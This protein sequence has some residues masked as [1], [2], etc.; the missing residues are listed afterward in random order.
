MLPSEIPAKSHVINT[1]E[2]ST[3]ARAAIAMVFTSSGIP[4][5]ASGIDPSDSKK[6]ARA[7][8]VYENDS[9]NKQGDRHDAHKRSQQHPQYSVDSL[10]RHMVNGA[11][12]ENVREIPTVSKECVLEIAH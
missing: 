9:D 2:K 12:R 3:K 7:A 5:G 8:G 1:D 4:A 6:D 10:V 11:R